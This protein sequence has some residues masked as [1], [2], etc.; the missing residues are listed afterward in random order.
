[1]F[2]NHTR[3]LTWSSRTSTTS[4]RL[5]SFAELNH[6]P[7]YCRSILGSQPRECLPDEPRSDTEPCYRSVPQRDPT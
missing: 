3:T 2:C 6:L 4:A 1:M 7:A 5:E